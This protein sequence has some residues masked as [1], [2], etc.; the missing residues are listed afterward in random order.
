MSRSSWALAETRCRGAL[1]RVTGEPGRRE[2]R[3]LP[4]AV[5]ATKYTVILL[6]AGLLIVAIDPARA[7]AAPGP[8]HNPTHT[9]PTPRQIVLAPGSGYT[10]GPTATMVRGLQRR[11]DGLG[12]SPGPIDGRY[13]PRTQRAVER[14]Q[15]AHGLRV[16]GIAGPITQAALRT[17]ATVLYP[18]AGYTATGSS[19]VRAL[20]RRL[21][22]DGY[23]PGPIDGRYGPRTSNAVRRFQAAHHLQIDGI[24]GPKTYA[25]LNNLTTP[26]RHLTHPTTRP[27]HKTVAPPKSVS[28]PNTVS[29]PK[30][31]SPPNTVSPPKTVSPPSRPRAAAP[32]GSS[33]PVVLLVLAGLIILAAL[34]GGIWLIGR[35]RRAPTAAEPLPAVES[36]PEPVRQP[37]EAED[38]MVLGARLMD[39]GDLAGAIRAFRVADERGDP[40][41]A[42]NLGVLLEDQGDLAAAEAAYRRADARGSAD[43]AFNL[44]AMLHERGDTEDAI[45]AYRRAD[46]R[47]DARA[48]ATV[49]LL[50]FERGD[51]AEAE[52][53]LARAAARGDAGSMVNLGVLRERRGDTG[54]AEA[55]YRQA[56]QHGSADGAFNLGAL[57]EQQGDLANALAAYQRADARG[58][59][60]AAL[61]LGI[62]LER[63]A[64]YH[65]ALAAYQRAEHSDQPDIAEDARA[66]AQAL[67]FGL[68]LGT[69]GDRR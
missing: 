27:H 65:R 42:S 60:G 66:R 34:A 5:S 56:D 13:G 33:T 28:P 46:D 29:P 63:R 43:G 41:G 62:L 45:A 16:D 19:A 69:G 25:R 47:G 37:E 64:D 21:R 24:A 15:S 6:A 1:A 31:V 61:N 7:L 53:A 2:R 35:R 58:D 55:A 32:K 26:K 12:D 68:S 48:A 18:G 20:Q 14:F 54:D 22:A 8:G 4:S 59:T 30:T 51:E 67:A 3:F 38:P 36:G 57:L 40:G 50:L 52:A 39:Q 23:S 9:A 44:G 11:L 17:P 10:G 49:G